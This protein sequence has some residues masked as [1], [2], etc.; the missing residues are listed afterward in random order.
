MAEAGSALDVLVQEQILQLLAE[1]QHR[2]H[3]S[4]L[5]ITHDLAVVRQMADDVVVMQEGRVM[6]TGLTDEIFDHPA[7]AYTRDLIDAI[8]GA[9][10]PLFTGE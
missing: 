1:I 5:F 8:P 3:I 2:E 4:Y 9:K 6:E 7:E 10:I